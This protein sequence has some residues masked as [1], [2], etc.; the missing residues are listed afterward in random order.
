LHVLPWGFAD[1]TRALP[2][3][4]PP[5]DAPPITTIN[6]MATAMVGHVAELR[7]RLLITVGSTIALTL[8]AFIWAEPLTRGW[9]NMAPRHIQ[10]VALA[11]G[12]AF[13]ASLK[14]CLLTGGVASAPVW[15]YHLGQFVLPGLHAPERKAL[16]WLVAAGLVLFAA[17]CMLGLTLIAPAA[18]TWMLTFGQGLATPQL[19]IRAYLDFML[20]AVLLTGVA[21]Q[22]PLC[23]VG[24][25]LT[26]LVQPATLVAQW[27]QALVGIF[28][29]SA[30]LTPGQ[31][32]FSM[33]VTGALLCGLYGLSLLVVVR[34]NR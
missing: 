5:Q 12:E 16:V 10:F 4:T 25:V 33:G 20:A 6:T 27:R 19:S 26:G 22:L 13:M 32:P 1:A 3:P 21:F 9:L 34:L 28:V 30:L 23:V 2:P 24:A 11:P 18:I 14:V 7:T 29:A 17:G 15:L 8:L 31:D